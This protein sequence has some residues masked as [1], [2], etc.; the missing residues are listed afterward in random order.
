MIPIY[1]F[2]QKLLDKKWYIFITVHWM[3]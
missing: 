3:T 2:Y 1:I